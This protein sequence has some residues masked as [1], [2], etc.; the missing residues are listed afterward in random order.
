MPSQPPLAVIGTCHGL[1]PPLLIPRCFLAC[2]IYLPREQCLACVLA[3]CRR[4][5][6]SLDG[7]RHVRSAQSDRVGDPSTPLP[8]AAVGQGAGLLLT[9]C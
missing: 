9:T 3:L 5:S 8:T 1:R 6:E 7:R 2:G 4:K